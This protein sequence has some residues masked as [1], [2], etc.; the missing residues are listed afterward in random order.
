MCSNNINLWFYGKQGQ[1]CLS[2]SQIMGPNPKVFFG[3]TIHGKFPIT[4]KCTAMSWT[5]ESTHWMAAVL[6]QRR[7]GDKMH[8]HSLSPF[9]SLRSYKSYSQ[10]NTLLI[11][12]FQN[13][14]FLGH[15]G[16]FS[17]SMHTSKN[18]AFF[19]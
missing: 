4:S 2:R 5:P 18:Q 13:V 3:V 17:I 10:N 15:R 7:A 12:H 1:E 14:R 8:T 11:L 16:I 9:V 6:A 19:S